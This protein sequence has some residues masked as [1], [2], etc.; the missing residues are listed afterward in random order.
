MSEIKLLDIKSD[1]IFKQVFGA[2]KNK[3]LLISLINSILKGNPTVTDLQI[4]NTEISKILKGN[5]TIRL[6]IKA[7]VG[8]QQYVNIEIQVRN[9]GEIIERAV[10][11]LAEMLTENFRELTEEEK[12]SGMVQSYKY[13][14]AIGIWIMGQNVTNRV[15]AVNEAGLSFAPTEMEKYEILTDKLRI[16]FIEL[17]KF[18][19]QHI[20]RKNMLDVW[21]AFLNNPLN[22]EVEDIKEVHKALDTLKE[23]SADREVREIYEM[24]RKTDMGYL[25]EK[26]I[27]VENAR[28]EGKAEGEKLG[29]EKE[30]I[31][32]EKEKLEMAKRMIS[33]GLSTKQVSQITQLSIEEINKIKK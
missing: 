32:A 3:D 4:R 12:G 25:S 20:D 17:P 33:A 8:H 31:K 5:R 10:Q 7:E 11:Y 23:V 27:A 13:P 9:T 18:H 21:M 30:R 22:K 29:A 1:Y 15:N 6:D 19:P 14:K 16:F 26:N 2:E 24:R 28:Q